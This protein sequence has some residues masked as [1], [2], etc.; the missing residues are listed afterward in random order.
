MAQNKSL[1]NVTFQT[2][3]GIRSRMIEAENM[4]QAREKIKQSY[5]RAYLHGGVKIISTVKVR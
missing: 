5:A 1:Y 4:W 3:S 2:A